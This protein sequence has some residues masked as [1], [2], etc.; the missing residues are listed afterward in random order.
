MYIEGLWVINFETKKPVTLALKKSKIS[1]WLFTVDV[2]HYQRCLCLLHLSIVFDIFTLSWVGHGRSG[3]LSSYR[4]WIGFL[5]VGLAT[6][7]FSASEK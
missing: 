7:Q 3:Q 6:V 1:V 4:I 2:V 5:I